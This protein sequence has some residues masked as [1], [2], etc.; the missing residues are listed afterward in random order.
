MPRH[1]RSGRA[2]VLSVIA[3]GASLLSGC[4]K[5]QARTVPDGPALQVPAPPAR[6]VV[7]ALG[8]GFSHPLLDQLRDVVKRIHHDV[9]VPY[10]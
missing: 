1:L 4:A 9:G 5:M 8:H 10:P 3:V 7:A 6:E 2:L